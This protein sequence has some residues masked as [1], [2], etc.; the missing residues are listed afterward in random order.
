MKIADVLKCKQVK[1]R[2]PTPLRAKLGD[3]VKGKVVG[4]VVSGGTRLI[5]VKLDGGSKQLFRPQ[6]VS[7][8]DARHRR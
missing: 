2:V 7:P 6:D 8:I 4:I 5:Q 3:E 1:V